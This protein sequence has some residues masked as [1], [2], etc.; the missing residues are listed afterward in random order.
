M[1]GTI[2][3]SEA[4]PAGVDEEAEVG[5]GRLRPLADGQLPAL[6]PGSS[7]GHLG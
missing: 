6:Q 7:L 4:L 3:A 1:L 5:V 2:M